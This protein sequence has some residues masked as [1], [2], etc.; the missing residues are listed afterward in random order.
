MLK[1]VLL[2]LLLCF[3][4]LPGTA[5]QLRQD[6]VAP[7]IRTNVSLVLVP[8]TVTD[9]RG[10]MVNGLDRTNFTV[11]E[12]KVPQPIVAFTAQDAPA[13][14]GLIFDSSGSMRDNLDIAKS[15]VRAFADGANPEDEAFLLT[16]ASRP[17]VHSEFTSD[18]GALADTLQFATASGSTALIDTVYA[19]LQ[20]MRSAAHARR[21]LLIVSDGMDNNSRYSKSELMQLALEADVQVYTIAIDSRVRTRKAI[22]LQEE[23]RGLAFME[24]LAERTG[25]LH[26]AINSWE[27]TGRVVGAALQALRNQYVIGYQ[28][29]E[30]DQPGKWHRIRVKLN[31]ANTKVS[32]RNGYYSR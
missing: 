11:L 7:S 27:Q 20:R 16:V 10:A 14:V 29:A 17:E 23:N 19:G 1:K 22:E 31:L 4:S 26:F 3:P 28:P 18:L 6:L 5:Q 8:V 15:A 12:D 32:A 21:A 25:G 24:D 9:R 2:I 30:T 13:S